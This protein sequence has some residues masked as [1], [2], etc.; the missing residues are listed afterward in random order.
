MKWAIIILDMKKAVNI[1]FC[2]A[3]IGLF[4]LSC[5]EDPVIDDPQSPIV[6]EPEE[7]VVYAKELFSGYVQKGPYIIGSSVTIAQ[8][9][10]ALN[11][12][13]NVFTTQI[14]DN[15]GTF[16]QRNIEFAS[17]FVELKAEGYY[18][19]EVKGAN[20]TGPLTLYALTDITDINSVNVNILTHLE[21][22]RIIYLI[23]AEE[24]SFDDAKKQARNEVLNIFKLSLSDDVAIESL[25]IADDALLLTVSVIVQGHLPTGDLSELLANISADIRTDGKLDNP[26]LST[27]LI[28]NVAFLNCEKVISN[29]EKKYSGL[30]ISVN[31]SAD[32]LK[33]YIEQFKNNCGFEQT[34]SITYPES[35]AFGLNIL[36]DSFVEADGLISSGTTQ[37][38]YM[39]IAEVP[40]GASLK[41]IIKGINGRWAGSVGIIGINGWKFEKNAENDKLF[42]TVFTIEGGVTGSVEYW[43]FDTSSIIEF[44][45][46]GATEP[47]KTKEIKV[48]TIWDF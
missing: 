21:R 36:A 17:N 5:G 13:G 34:L 46:N 40:E 9:D 3:L 28:N 19:D 38:P 23:Q 31:V 43:I 1:W 22:Q 41:I 37:P 7:P 11:Q 12:T 48:N 8:L 2:I 26:V 15:S 33:G 45:E 24:L 27:Q 14:V 39:I 29:M 20:S 30:G 44:Y 35:G 10:S 18:F 4:A 25:N 16:E 42:A 32:E 6:E 47:T